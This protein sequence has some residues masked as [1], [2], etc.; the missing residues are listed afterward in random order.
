VALLVRWLFVSSST[1]SSPNE[2]ATVLTRKDELNSQIK[3]YTLLVDQLQR[4]NTIIWQFPTAL[5]GLNGLAVVQLAKQPWWLLAV[6]VFNLSMIF[7][8]LKI[9]MRQS[10]LIDTTRSAEAHL[11]GEFAHFVPTFKPS[12][13]R[14]PRLVYRT[15]VVLN[16]A[17]GI[18]ALWQLH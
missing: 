7:G 14:A 1:R 12:W 16:F 13:I 5:V 17:L 6:W 4:Y 10:V 3:L 9:I 18:Y 8:F 2:P 11:Q 15:L